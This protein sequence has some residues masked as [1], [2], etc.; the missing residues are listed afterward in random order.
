[1]S[2]LLKQCWSAGFLA[3]A[4]AADALKTAADREH[5]ALEENRC[6]GMFTC[7]LLLL[8]VL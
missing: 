8:A 3:A 4:F 2:G 6:G 1:V 7:Q 5:L